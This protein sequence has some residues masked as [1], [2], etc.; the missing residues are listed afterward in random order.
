[1]LTFNTADGSFV[2]TPTAGYT[3]TDS[4]TY[5]LSNGNGTSAPAAAPA[6]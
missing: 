4:F 1:M 6:P 5:T 2:Y 3:G